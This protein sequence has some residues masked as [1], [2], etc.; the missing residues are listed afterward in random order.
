MSSLLK[1][2]KLQRQKSCGGVGTGGSFGSAPFR[3]PS[4][5]SQQSKQSLPLPGCS[6][7][8]GGAGQ[9]Q[10][11]LLS[12]KNTNPNNNNNN[13]HHHHYQH[14]RQQSTG[15]QQHSDSGTG[16][17]RFDKRETFKWSGVT[18]SFD[19]ESV[20]IENEVN[21]ELPGIKKIG[22]EVGLSFVYIHCFSKR[23]LIYNDI[24]R[25]TTYTSS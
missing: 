22:K 2:S 25:I 20:K 11:P 14:H 15:A 6:S 7:G 13:R 23:K 16:G 18:V 5:D 10:T 4:T 8:G 24:L 9:N 17:S 19:A 3:G 1:T 12:R 21:G